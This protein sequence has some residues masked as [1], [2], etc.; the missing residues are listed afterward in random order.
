MNLTLSSTET[1]S[2]LTLDGSTGEGGGQIL[3]TGLALSMVT[4]RP[5]HITRIRAGRPKPGLMRQHLACVQAA[6]AVSGGQADGA[7]LG[8]QT[9]LFTPGAV[10]AG[11]YRFQIATA[12]S[13]LLVLQTVLPAL[14]LGHGESRVQLS[15][16]THNPMAPPFDFLK[17]SFAPLV[18]RLGV[19]LDLQLQ[20]RGFYPAGG[21]ELVAHITP[22]AQ[23]LTPADVVERGALLN[24]YGEALV[25]GLA[26]NIAH[27][28]LEALGQRMGWTFE[29]GQLRN[30]PTR[31]NEGPGNALIATLE[32]EHVTEVFCQL[33]ERSLSAEQVA[34]RLADE[35]RTYQRSQGALGPHLADQWMLPLALAVWRSGRAARYTCT[36]VTQ[37]TATN[38]Q[39]IALGLPVRVEITPVDR[40]MRV[41]ISPLR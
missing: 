41:E 23:P 34:K 37:H 9:L 6:V 10:R 11:D 36:E 21:G 24:A 8:S 38:A 14:M 40:A 26:R 15:G 31:Q 4:G 18:R 35:V 5:L 12:G 7:E 13:C 19:G 1:A 22:S 2:P 29:A 39:T 20:R 28:E 3:R 30:P 16:G 25:P 33:G 32:Y 17:R 27:R